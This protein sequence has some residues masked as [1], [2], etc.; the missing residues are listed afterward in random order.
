MFSENNVVAR[1]HILYTITRIKDKISPESTVKYSKHIIANQIAL[2]FTN[3]IYKLT[4]S[5]LKK[6]ISLF[7][8]IRREL[9]HPKK[10]QTIIFAAKFAQELLKKKK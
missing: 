8:K 5:F 7:L 3:H 10:P 2:S 4:E 6:P 1:L 9:Q